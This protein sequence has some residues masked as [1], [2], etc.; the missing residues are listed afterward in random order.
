[1]EKYNKD[2]LI[3]EYRKQKAEEG[4]KLSVKEA[5]DDV[6]TIFSSI[7]SVMGNG[8]S[9]EPNKKGVRAKLQII[10]F[11]VFDLVH[12]KERVFGNPQNPSEPTT[13]KAHNKLVFSEGKMFTEIINPVK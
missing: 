8:I 5:R 13:K 7:M 2:D 4:I 12:R 1:M 9:A 10:N 6:D 3:E 11:G